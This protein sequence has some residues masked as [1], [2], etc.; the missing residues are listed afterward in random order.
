MMTGMRGTDRDGQA[1]SFRDRDKSNSIYRDRQRM[2]IYKATESDIKKNK[3]E[4]R[5]C[6]RLAKRKV[7]N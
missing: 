7:Y 1:K 6:K 5:G 2:R 4:R 3:D